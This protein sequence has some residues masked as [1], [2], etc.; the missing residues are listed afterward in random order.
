VDVLLGDDGSGKQCVVEEQDG[1]SLELGG[2][3]D[4]DVDQHD[5]RRNDEAED[6]NEEALPK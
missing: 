6:A 4:I 1:L 5:R 3:D 2:G